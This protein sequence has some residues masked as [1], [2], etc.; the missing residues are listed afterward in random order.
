MFKKTDLRSEPSLLHRWLSYVCE[1]KIQTTSSI[2]NP[3]LEVILS[4]GRFQLNTEHATYSFEDLYDNYYRTFKKYNLQNHQLQKVLVL[5]LGLGS[6]PLMLQ[7]HF[8]QSQAH[9]FGVEI[10]EVVIEL[11]RKYIKPDL[12]RRLTTFC[13]DAYDFVG[14]DDMQ[15][16]LIAVDIFLDDLTPMKFR[17][18]PFLQ[19]LKRLLAP[20]A[21]LF[22]N[23]M[24]VSSASYL[25][26]HGFFE[27]RFL[28]TFPNAEV[29]QMN[30]NRM[31]IFEVK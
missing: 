15:Y 14:R 19:N 6:V 20:N 27:N 5:G 12:S 30:S 26:S 22:Y 9:F 16:D 7:S 11:C 23:T 13:E 31:L 29:F 10:D 24:T 8:K 25:E 1:Q 21:F 28:P 18:I 3:Y 2:F 17:S 4:R